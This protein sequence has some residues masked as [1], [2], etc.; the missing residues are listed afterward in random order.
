MPPRPSTVLAVLA[1]FAALTAASPAAHAEAPP[2]PPPVE[3][4]GRL[5][6]VEMMQLSPSGERLAYVRVKGDARELV[7]KTVAGE[8]VLVAPV[9]LSKIR[10]LD[11]AGEDRLVITAS[12]AMTLAFNDFAQG[13]RFQSLVINLK[14][15]KV[16]K[17]FDGKADMYPMTFGFNGAVQRGDRWFG[18]FLGIARRSTGYAEL[19]RVDLDSGDEQRAAA[20][21]QR[22]HAWAQDDTGAIV[23]TTEFNE[24]AGDWTLRAGGEG[25]PVVATLHDSLGGMA[26]AGLGRGPG[27]VVIDADIPEEWSLADGAHKPLV[28]TGRVEGEIF[29][30]RS[31]RLVGAWMAEDRATQRFFEP[32]LA[33]R[34]AALAK[35][36]GSPP[37]LL[38]WSADYRR[39]VAF[40]EGDRDA[41][42]Y[43][44]V[45]GGSVKPI[46]YAYP[47][48]PDAA[49]GETR[50]IAYKAADGLDLRGV[51][52]LPPGREPHNLPVVVIPHGGP[53]ARDTVRFDYWAQAFAA[54]GY[55]VFQPNFRGSSGY[56]AAFRDA[57]F[58]Q[59]GRKM[60]TD[61]SDGLADLARHGVVD[62]KR[63]CIFGGSYG[64]YAALAGVTV[65][66]GLYRCA[67]SY[68]GISDL[69]A[70]LQQEAPA[71]A[72]NRNASVRYLRRFLGVG[73]DASLKDLSPAQLAGRADAP[74]LLIHGADDTVVPISHAR[75]MESALRKAGKP[76]EFVLLKSEDH[77]LSRQAT[78]EAMLSAAVDFVMRNNPPDR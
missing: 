42:T 13:E 18:Y 60:Q 19:Y 34:Q 26:L 51:L 21:Y 33:G 70:L 9:G 40:T 53:E 48:I 30:P 2:S 22:P 8:A 37:I 67:V 35:A 66:Q 63:A 73:L 54:R 58:G 6:D 45:D 75:E 71:D 38:T 77:W 16:L 68:G 23:A 32:A 39:I 72:D 36:L 74:I 41:G 43:W 29:D 11:W 46:A 12:S 3:A 49:V 47:A 64:G 61:I 52:T 59:W 78:R 20:G 7:I 31:H 14:S 5:P 15:Q 1:A 24:S 28:E 69:G 44:L 25:A 56:G 10:G 4:Y 65:Q 27:S 76:V 55:A 17:V 57:G 62:P 50:M